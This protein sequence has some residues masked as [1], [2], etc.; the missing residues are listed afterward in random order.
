MKLYYSPGA[1]SLSPNI[2]LREAGVAF[3]LE[4]VDTST[5]KT[6]TNADFLQINPK[7]Y[8]PVL[9]LD[10]GEI[11]T[12]GAAIVQYVADQ[13]P[14]SGLAPKAGT[15]ERARLQEHLNFT[16]SEL[17]KAFG[18]LFS[19]DTSEAG[20]QAVRAIVSTI[21]IPNHLLRYKAGSAI[22]QSVG[23]QFWTPIPRLR[24]SILQAE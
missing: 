3:D 15:I 18:P 24:G 8:V 5:K 23:G 1:C 9:R 22:D 11:L 4:R 13:R 16:A 14:D 6:E 12:E 17:H 19:P 2:V 21:S 20:K 10:D 7:G